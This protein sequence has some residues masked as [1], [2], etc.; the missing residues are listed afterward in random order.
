MR[1]VSSTTPMTSRDSQRP[2]LGPAPMRPYYRFLRFLCRVITM[3]LFKARVSG[4]RNVPATGPVLLVCNHQSHLDPVLAT[5]ALDREASFM[6]RDNLFR[7]RFF[8]SLIES[9]NAFPIR[10]NTADMSAIKESLRR[11][12]H[13]WALVL[14]PE[15]TRT[16]DGRIQPMLPGLGAIARKAAVPIV[17]TL[18]D[19]AF[20]SWP[21]QS[22]LPRPGNVIIEYGRP[23][24]PGEY[25]DKTV[26]ELMEMVRGR[27]VAMQRR[28]H[29][30]NPSRRLQ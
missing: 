16:P 11:L 13:G 22:P 12:R 17:P 15:G 29:G 5:M 30:R 4:R 21:R 23:I 26:E 14:F 8:R 28:W 9:L 18:I 25:A 20:Q 7:N 2:S 19:G 24:F 6:A 3:L 10:R 27:L 1:P